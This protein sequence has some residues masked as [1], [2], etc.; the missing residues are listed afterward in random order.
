MVSRKAITIES[1]T[2]PLRRKGDSFSHQF[3]GVAVSLF[4]DLIV[5][6]MSV[7]A[8]NIWCL[9]QNACYYGLKQ[10]MAIAHDGCYH[11]KGFGLCG[12][13]ARGVCGPAWR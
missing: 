4:A 10:Y 3:T 9:I 5:V 8:V 11:H 13:A 2:R 1:F 7:E 12:F 6:L